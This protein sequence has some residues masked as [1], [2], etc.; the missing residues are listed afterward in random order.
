MKPLL[1]L[2]DFQTDYLC[3]PGIEP[4]IGPVVER[5]VQLLLFCRER[6]I[7][8]AHVRTAVTRDPDNRMP[9]WRQSGRWICESVTPGQEPPVSLAARP[10]E[11]V[12]LKS[13]L[14]GFA[15]TNLSELLRQREI[16]TLIV[17]G[18]H[19]HECVRQTIID[20]CQS[21]LNVRVADDAVASDDPVHAATTRRYLEARAVRFV[22]VDALG[23]ELAGAEERPTAG[24]FRDLIRLAVD[25]AANCQ[26]A[27]RAT[28]RPQRID[29]A[30]KFVE[31]LARDAEALARLIVE[32]IGKPVQFSRTEVQRTGEM[33]RAIIA[34]STALPEVETAG[35]AR[36]RRQ[37][38]GNVAVITPFNNPVYLPLGKILPAV[39]HGNTVVWKSAPEATRVSRHVMSLSRDAGWPDGLVSL[40]E[41][42][43]REGEALL[44]DPR[45]DAVT[46]T[47]SSGAGHSAQEACARRRIPLQAELGGNN[48]A[49]VW[50][51]GDLAIAAREVAAGAFDLAGQ[52]CTAN[53]RVVVHES[54]RDDFIS[55]LITESRALSCGDP[56]REETRIG[57]LVSSRR[58]EFVAGAVRRAEAVC[59]QLFR[60]HGDGN[61]MPGPMADCWYPPTIICCDDPRHEII[62]EETFGPVLVVQTARDWRQAIDLCNGVRQGLCA[63]I[64]TGSSEVKSRFLDEAQAGILKLNSSTADAAVDVPF[65]GWKASGLGPPEHGVFDVEFYTRCQT[66]YRN[67]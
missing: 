13:G 58:R 16:D 1:A 6:E 24:N 42:D 9:H 40:L 2:I 33:L 25:P 67:D 27:W 54:L 61:P 59:E 44:R 52:R 35:P 7:P 14:S 3:A 26:P 22:S 31:G 50:S 5:A 32:E 38:H 41:G 28:P 8:I 23:R 17:A 34:R 60:P 48:A 39:L 37:P 12:I 15:G 66:V 53:R 62:Q 64:F 56:R 65:G 55:R 36:V 63:A 21:G 20:A 51:D 45:I 46:I 47:G 57:P 4:A 30:R 11:A 18:I 19:L 10:G 49:I 43:R 29:L